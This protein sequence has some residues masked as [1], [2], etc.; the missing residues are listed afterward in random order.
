MLGR[1]SFFMCLRVIEE[2]HELIREPRQGRRFRASCTGRILAAA[3]PSNVMCF[4]DDRHE[5]QQIHPRLTIVASSNERL[6]GGTP[7]DGDITFSE[8]RSDSSSGWKHLLQTLNM[9]RRLRQKSGEYSR[10]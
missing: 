1:D 3:R 10:S 6:P 7:F 4:G 5:G 2:R 9:C 8:G